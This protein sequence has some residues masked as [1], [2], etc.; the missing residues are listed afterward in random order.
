MYKLSMPYFVYIMA[1]Q[2]GTLYIGL[3]NRLERRVYEHKQGLNEGFTKK[4]KC[5]KLVYFETHQDIN[6]AKSRE[7]QVKKYRREKKEY[8]I[9]DLNPHWK[10]L[11][12]NWISI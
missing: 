11:S 3:T 6:E 7:R 2:S 1:S 10:D 8:L 4:Y 12:L 9:K 5:D